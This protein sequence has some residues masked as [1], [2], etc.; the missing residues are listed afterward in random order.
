[1]KQA[2]FSVLF[3]A[4]L[5]LLSVASASDVVEKQNEKQATGDLLCGV[6]CHNGRCCGYG[7]SCC[8]GTGC[9][10]SGQRCCGHLLC[11]N[12]EEYTAFVNAHAVPSRIAS[13]AN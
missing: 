7:E 1:M 13:I 4:A 10:R 3:L 9:C 6:S 5:L 12:V 2:S 11:C 8:S